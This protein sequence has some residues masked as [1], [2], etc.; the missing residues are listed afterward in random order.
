MGQSR[1]A[2]PRRVSRRS[3]AGAGSRLG[4]A[5]LAAAILLGTGASACMGGFS[6]ASLPDAVER[7]RARASRMEISVTARGVLPHR[8]RLSGSAMVDVRTGRLR[9]SL[10]FPPLPP[11][12]DPG[13]GD[14]KLPR[15]VEVVIDG[16]TVYAGSEGLVHRL[17]AGTRWVRLDTDRARPEALDLVVARW[18]AYEPAWLLEALRGVSGSLATAGSERVGGADTTHY[19]GNLDAR[20]AVDRARAGIRRQVGVALEQIRRMAG[21]VSFPIDLWVDREG[22][23]RRVRYQLDLPGLGRD[24]EPP[25]LTCTVDFGGLG[26]LVDVPLPPAGRITDVTL[27]RPGPPEG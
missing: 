9:M 23:I 26:E 2:A 15:R 20:A 18:A 5:F 24:G 17:G 4:L 14:I 22:L 8:L 16:S 11:P 10:R 25:K 1:C 27:R 3:G 21:V 7:T 12:G 19:R 6:S 13:A